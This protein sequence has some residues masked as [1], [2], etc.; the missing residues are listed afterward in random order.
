MPCRWSSHLF[1]FWRALAQLSISITV[2]FSANCEI[3]S[4]TVLIL[5]QEFI[6]RGRVVLHHLLTLF[7]VLSA[8]TMSLKSCFVQTCEFRHRPW[9]A[10]CKVV[11]LPSHSPWHPSRHVRHCACRM[12]LRE[13]LKMWEGRGLFTH[14]SD[15][16]FWAPSGLLQPHIYQI[17]ATPTP[18]ISI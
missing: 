16:T 10:D 6:Y 8:A 13:R 18:F 3:I 12:W 2:T 4:C 15:W 9:L 11:L 14:L 17:T 5:A 1:Y 7:A